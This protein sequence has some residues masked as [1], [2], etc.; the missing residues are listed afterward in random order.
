MKDKA[1]LSPLCIKGPEQLKGFSLG[2]KINGT[3]EIR[4]ATLMNDKLIALTGSEWKSGKE[5]CSWLIHGSFN[6]K[7]NF[8]L[9]KDYCFINM[10]LFLSRKLS[11]ETMMHSVPDC[12]MIF[13]A[14]RIGV[15][16]G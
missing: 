5:I 12:R 10:S 1:K 9:N 16:T 13:H 8:E 11:M 4:V 14:L 3:V 7:Y 2:R 6:S 15:S